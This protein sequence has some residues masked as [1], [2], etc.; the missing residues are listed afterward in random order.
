M[1]EKSGF[2][3]RGLLTLDNSRGD[4]TRETITVE[5][6]VVSWALI[7]LAG[8]IAGVAFT[9]VLTHIAL[10]SSSTAAALGNTALGTEIRRDAAVVTQLA[11]PEDN[12]VQFQKVFTQGAVVGTFRE[13]GIFDAATV[14]NMFNRVVFT[15]FVVGSSDTLTVTWLIEIRNS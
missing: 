14:G 11:A 12:K 3:I 15:D 1:N 8:V 6:M 4:G 13:A 7:K 10:G 5:N 9:N 2:G